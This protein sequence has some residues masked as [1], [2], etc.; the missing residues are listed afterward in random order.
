MTKEHPV[1]TVLV[2]LQIP[3]RLW[4]LIAGDADALDTSVADLIVEREQQRYAPPQDSAPD[5]GDRP[6][7][8]M[9]A[10]VLAKRAEGLAPWQIADALGCSVANVRYHLREAD[11]SRP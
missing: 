1:R 8:P 9:R 5:A 10:K 11:R 6:R 4:W 7:G 2:P 3:G